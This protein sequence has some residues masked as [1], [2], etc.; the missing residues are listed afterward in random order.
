MDCTTFFI[1]GAGKYL[2]SFSVKIWLG[3][4]WSIKTNDR[5]KWVS[6]PV[7]T[8]VISHHWDSEP[9]EETLVD[10]LSFTEFSEERLATILEDYFKA[11]YPHDYVSLT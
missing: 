10:M 6:I 3:S 11:L 2:P 4:N 5:R 1:R 9:P 8:I 7:N